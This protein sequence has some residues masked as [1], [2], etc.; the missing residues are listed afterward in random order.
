MVTFFAE[1]QITFANTALVI[2]ISFILDNEKVDSQ[3]I[4]FCRRRFLLHIG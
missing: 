2:I 3:V 4:M 1:Y